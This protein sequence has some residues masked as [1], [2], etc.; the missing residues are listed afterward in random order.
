MIPP[1][2]ILIINNKYMNMKIYK[3]KNGY[4]ASH[5]VSPIMAVAFTGATRMEAINKCLEYIFTPNEVI[6][7]L[8]E[9]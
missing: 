5:K 3:T 1:P 8:T 9:N 2:H 6:N 7:L 4:T